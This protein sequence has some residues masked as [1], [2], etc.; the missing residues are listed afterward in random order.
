M[1]VIASVGNLPFR[2]ETDAGAVRNSRILPRPG[3]VDASDFAKAYFGLPWEAPEAYVRHSP[4]T[5]VTRVKTPIL[6]Q[7]GENDRHIPIMQATQFYKA[8]KAREARDS[9]ILEQE[10]PQ[11]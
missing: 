8:I 5:Y 1:I 7:H 3:A 9:G 2:A 6:L 10:A 4:I 11:R